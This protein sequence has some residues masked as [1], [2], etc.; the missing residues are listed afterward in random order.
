MTPSISPRRVWTI[1][2]LLGLVT[3]INFADRGN[4]ATAAALIKRDLHL[5]ATQYGWL[6]SGFFAAYAPA[7]FIAGWLAEKFD[8]Y[9]TLAIGLLIWALATGLM[10]AAG[11]FG[12]LLLLRVLLGLGESVSYPC[13]S[14]IFSRLTPAS[15]RGL[16][17]GLIAAGSALGAAVGVWIGG[18][19]MAAFGWQP[20]FIGFGC[21]SL[22][23][24]APWLWATRGL[25]ASRSHPAGPDLI[26]LLRQ[27]GLWAAGAGQF[28]YAYNLY[29]V[30][31]WLPLYLVKA[32][33]LSM[34]QMA[35]LTGL[36]YLVYAVSG[37]L[38][39]A[40]VDRP[41]GHDAGARR[42][43][44]GHAWV[45]SG[46][47]FPLRRSDARDRRL[48]GNLLLLDLRHRPDHGRA[49]CGGPVDGG[50]ERPR[51]L[52]RD[53]RAAHHR[54]H[55]GRDRRLY[56]RFR[57]GGG[58]SGTGRYRL[59][60]AGPGDQTGRLVGAARL[61]LLAPAIRCYATPYP[62]VCGGPSPR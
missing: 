61:T 44:A 57:R 50:A 46:R 21:I 60:A 26:S 47:P 39:G 37:P 42:H 55:R 49:R 45:R 27:R 25:A 28:C 12:F 13:A 31:T 4:L 52:L 1:A 9:R 38:M 20:V 8:P 11:S 23:W 35:D 29:F 2:V 34:A 36:I 51:Q 10:G 41:R 18:R 58:H 43:A 16:A 7:N 24:L 56:G 54:R 53:S 22:I 62:V 33:G 17:N 15:R 19:L 14:L 6:V 59:V 32:K 40:L 3:F 5:S 30:L 48:R